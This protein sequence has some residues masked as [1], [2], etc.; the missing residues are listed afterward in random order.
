MID[1]FAHSSRITPAADGAFDARIDASW[2]QGRGAF[3]G[4]LAALFVRAIESKAG[5]DGRPFRTLTC[6]FCAPAQAGPARIEVE[7]PRTSS[8]VS[9]FTAR[10]IQDDGVVAIATAT[11]A[12]AR[13]VGFAFC[14]RRMPEA[15]A[16][17]ATPSLD[18]SLGGP[19]FARHFDFR[20][21]CGA[22]PFSGASRALFGGWLR[23]HNPGALDPALAAAYADA[24]MP[25]VFTR[26]TE[27]RPCATVTLTYHFFTD[28]ASG[29]EASPGDPVLITSRSDVVAGGY[30]EQYNEVWTRSGALV[31]TG[32][33]LLAVIR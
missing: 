17:E 6:H 3:G 23:H 9:H 2:F 33:Q 18:L 29:L 25:A 16:F 21:A 27:F 10:M 28:F 7:V 5:A 13:E 26:F 12:R 31:M 8:A 4:L 30:A 32:V 20:F 14:D 24:W 15:P 11:R 19:V 22:E 1:L